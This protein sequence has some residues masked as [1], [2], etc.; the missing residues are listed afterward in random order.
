[1]TLNEASRRF[2]ISMEKLSFYE[3][4]GLWNIRYFPMEYRI[5]RKP[6]FA[7]QDLFTPY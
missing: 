6:I 7:E 2:H 4:N 3:E 5:I 1:M